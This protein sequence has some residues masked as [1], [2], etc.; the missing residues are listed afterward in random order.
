MGYD[1]AIAVLVVKLMEASGESFGI[2]QSQV[3]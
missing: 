3:C 1:R 2:G